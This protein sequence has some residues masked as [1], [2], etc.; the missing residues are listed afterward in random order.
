MKYW[1]WIPLAAIVGLIAGSWGPREDLRLLKERMRE[2]RATKKVSRSAGFDAFAHLANI[3]D[4]A[5]RRPKNVVPTNEVAK[6][7]Q[8]EQPARTGMVAKAAAPTKRRRMSPEDLRAR[9]D[10]AAELWRTRVELA[11]VQWKDKLGASEG[12]RA[13]AF[14]SA[15]ACM[16]ASLRETMQAMADEIEAAGKMTPEL[17]LRLMGDASRV[18]AE[19]YDAIGAAVPED[20]RAE[21]S[22]MP[23]FEFIDPS[24]AEPLIGVQDKL[25]GCIWM[26]K[27]RRK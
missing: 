2:E 11:A 15:I 27:P 8:D 16:N 23:V 1:M 21:V 5:K 3:P 9:I 17:S 4:V 18:M 26:P 24:V 19:A 10:E 20:R 7:L 22:E 14:D 25:D 12:E 6:V 13:S